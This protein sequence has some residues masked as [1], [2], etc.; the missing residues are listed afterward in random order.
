M[1]DYFNQIICWHFKE[2]RFCLLG[3]STVSFL[4]HWIAVQKEF[5][6]F[7]SALSFTMIQ[8]LATSPSLLKLSLSYYQSMQPLKPFC[9]FAKRLL[10]NFCF[11]GMGSPSLHVLSNHNQSR[12]WSKNLRWGFNTCVSFWGWPFVKFLKVKILPFD[13]LWK[14]LV[15]ITNSSSDSLE[16]ESFLLSRSLIVTFKATPLYE[17]FSFSS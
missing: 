16:L 13:I 14:P 1:Q 8:M 10:F 4:E 17:D 5:S 7:S 12:Q 15:N 6:F 3:W 2:K 11:L 9:L